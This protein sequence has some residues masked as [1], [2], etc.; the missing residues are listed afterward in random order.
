MTRHRNVVGQRSSRQVAEQPSPLVALPSSHCSAG[1]S[2]PFP[3]ASISVIDP[4]PTFGLIVS[5]QSAKLV[6]KT[7][8]TV[9]REASTLKFSGRQS[10]RKA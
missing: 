4:R 2:R 3:Q 1:L 10:P 5:V 7:A 8:V 6:P 9:S